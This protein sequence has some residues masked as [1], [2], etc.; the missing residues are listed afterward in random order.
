MTEN[1]ATLAFAASLFSGLGGSDYW[2]RNM[3]IKE[4]EI[5][6]P[7]TSEEAAKAWIRAAMAGQAAKG[8]GLPN[9]DADELSQI[10]KNQ[11]KAS[12][13]FV[14]W[15]M[16]DAKAAAIIE[17]GGHMELAPLSKIGPNGDEVITGAGAKRAKGMIEVGDEAIAG[18]W[19]PYEMRQEIQKEWQAEIIQEGVDMGLDLTKANS[20]MQR[21]WNGPS[22]DPMIKGIADILFTRA[23]QPGISYEPTVKY[24][25]LNTTYVT[26][27]DGLPWATGVRRGG[28]LG[29]LGIKPLSSYYVS[30][31]SENGKNATGT[32]ERLNTTDFVNKLN[33]GMRALELKPDAHIPTDE[34]LTDMIAKAIEDAGRQQYTPMTPYSS[35]SGNGWRNFGGYGGWG[36]GGWGGFGGGGG[37]GYSSGYA[38]FEKMYRLP[39]GKAPYGDSIPFINTSNPLLRRESVRRERVWSERGKLKQWQ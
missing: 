11:A 27:P 1:R 26:G 12:G 4:R 35:K 30:E 28:L 23:G 9:L 34:E 24:N 22:S 10:W 2:R 37:G 33:T 6:K 3:V 13:T 20:R 16:L 39:Y 15:G 31:F 8:R 18:V 5:E 25:Q 19:I 29:A 38:N 32:D 21:L 7:E 17:Q 14:D 36:G